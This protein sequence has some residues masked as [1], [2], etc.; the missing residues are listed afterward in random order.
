[1][2]NRVHNSYID[3]YFIYTYICFS[4]SKL[5]A[6]IFLVSVL[7]TSVLGLRY[8]STMRECQNG[9]SDRCYMLNRSD[10]ISNRLTKGR[11]LIFDHPG[12][13]LDQTRHVAWKNNLFNA[14]TSV[15]FKSIRLPFFCV[16]CE[17]LSWVRFSFFPPLLVKPHPPHHP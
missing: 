14:I 7:S 5:A 2:W 4:L 13:R 10:I 1:M 3:I 9:K 6:T 15:T 17:A 16:E 12:A 8:T 11:K